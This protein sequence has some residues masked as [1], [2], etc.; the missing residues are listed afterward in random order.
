MSAAQSLRPVHCTRAILEDLEAVRENLLALSDDI[1][2]GIDRQ[3]LAAFD[4]GVRFMRSYV[5]KMTAFD[6]LAADLSVLI[7]QYTQ[8]SLEATEETGREDR[9]KN[10]RIIRELNREEP[11]SIGEDF[12]YKRP[13]GFI[14]AGQGTSGIT[15][16]QRLFELVCRQ[17]Y[18]RDPGRFASLGDDPEFISNRGH[19]SVTTDAGSLRK[20]LQIDDGLFIECNLSANGIRDMIRR[21]L[22]A[23]DLEPGEVRLFL[24]QDRDAGRVGALA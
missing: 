10:E 11:H 16:W 20:A 8:V 12:T 17:L 14:L 7:Q 4:E 15:T 19:H 13:H 5:E 23:F 9:E 1:W 21:L 24:R 2:A 3:D 22:V 18:Q 6:R